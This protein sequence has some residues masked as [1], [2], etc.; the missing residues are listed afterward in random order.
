VPVSTTKH[1]ASSPGSSA[2]GLPLPTWYRVAVLLLAAHL[3]IG[4]ARLP[5]KVFGKRTAE[6]AGY[7]QGAAQH[8]LANARLRGGDALAWLLDAAPSEVAVL[9]RWPV[10]GA[11]EFAPALLSPRLLVDERH[12]PIGAERAA[13]RPLFR[14]TLPDGRRGLVVVHA[15]ADGGLALD[16]RER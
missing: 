5:D 7:R 11:V 10:D 8:L 4:V 15:T 13:G 9:L 6:I 1:H 3:V 2:T 16:V 12:V 14:G